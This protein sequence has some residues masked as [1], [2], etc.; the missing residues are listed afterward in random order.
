MVVE[1]F[2][3]QY[4]TLTVGDCANQLEQGGYQIGLGD[5]ENLGGDGREY[6]FD[7]HSHH[8][9]SQNHPQGLPLHPFAQCQS[10]HHLGS[11]FAVIQAGDRVCG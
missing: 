11:K 9:G 1:M 7:E 3:K 6:C 4:T 5:G 8:S 10:S 2:P